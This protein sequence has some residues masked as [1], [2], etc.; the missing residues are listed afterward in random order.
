VLKLACDNQKSSSEVTCIEQDQ[1]NPNKLAVGYLDGTIRLFN[2][3]TKPQGPSNDFSNQANQEQQS[4][5]CFLTFNGHKT[6]ITSINF[7][8][9]GVKLVSGSKD[10]ELVVWDLIG[11]CGLF[12]LKGH[13]APIN[14]AIFMSKLN[15]LISW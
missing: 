13:K 4:I 12:R 11:E 9:Q 2:L 15:V 14:K 10:T 6:S 5:K 3:K 8:S 7:D 1:K